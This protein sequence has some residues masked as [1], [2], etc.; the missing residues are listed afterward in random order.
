MQEFR[1]VFRMRIR[2]GSGNSLHVVMQCSQNCKGDLMSVKATTNTSGDLR[3]F[4]III[5][6]FN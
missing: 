2:R 3:Y 4:H 5:R 1:L 6:D